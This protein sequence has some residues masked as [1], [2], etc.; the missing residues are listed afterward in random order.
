M[1]LVFKSMLI[2]LIIFIIIIGL[3]TIVMLLINILFPGEEG[4]LMLNWKINM[5]KA[6]KIEII[7]DEMVGISDSIGLQIWEYD[8]KTVESIIN[9]EKF[10]NIDKN[11]IVSIKEDLHNYYNILSE[12]QKNLFN[13]IDVESLLS[14]DNYF[15]GTKK[16]GR[17]WVL[18]ILNT[19][20][21]KLYYFENVM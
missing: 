2:P 16:E 11:D 8:N 14:E 6:N 15:A 5:P 10:S 17:S 7:Y 1:K 4:K 3:F 12:D 18:L 20:N 13:N 9:N 21:N 19:A